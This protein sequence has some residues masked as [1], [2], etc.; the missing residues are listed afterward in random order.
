MGV[1]WFHGRTGGLRHCI[2][3]HALILVL[4]SCQ[5]KCKACDAVHTAGC[6]HVTLALSLRMQVAW[7]RGVAAHSGILPALG[8][9]T[10]RYCTGYTW[11]VVLVAQVVVSV[12]GLRQLFPSCSVTV[13]PA[14]NAGNCAYLASCWT[15]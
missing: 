5:A 14:H 15:T 11:G 1:P 6:P 12:F 4:S 9:T 8:S 13:R 10:T 7:R 3:Q 2:K